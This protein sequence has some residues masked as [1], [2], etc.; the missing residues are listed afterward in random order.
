M[1]FLLF[2]AKK[3]RRQRGELMIYKKNSQWKGIWHSLSIS[4]FQ[5]ELKCFC[6]YT[7]WKHQTSVFELGSSDRQIERSDFRLPIPVPLSLLIFLL[8]IVYTLCCQS[9]V[10]QKRFEMPLSSASWMFWYVRCCLDLGQFLNS[11]ISCSDY[12]LKSSVFCVMA[13]GS[14]QTCQLLS[15]FRFSRSRDDHV[16]WVGFGVC[17][18]TV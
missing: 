8:S 5:A 14:G 9:R 10:L 13:A 4:G 17:S 1:F 18:E 6:P 3:G 15:A 11:S 16:T 12:Y 7:L 2:N